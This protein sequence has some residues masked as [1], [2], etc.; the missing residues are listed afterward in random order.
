MDNYSS[1]TADNLYGTG[2]KEIIPGENLLPI[3]L[4]VMNDDVSLDTLKLIVEAFPQGLVAADTNGNTPLH[5]A[6]GRK[7]VSDDKLSYLI[8]DNPAAAAIQRFNGSFHFIMLLSTALCRT[9]LS[10]AVSLQ[11]LENMIPL[12][13]KELFQGNDKDFPSEFIDP[14]YSPR[15]DM[16]NALEKAIHLHQYR[17]MVLRFFHDKTDKPSEARMKEILN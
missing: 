10:F 14:R 8:K 1:G 12:H 17:S 11:T 9:K 5:Y 13:S 6:F 7:K 16:L 2:R 15:Y 3:H 4:A